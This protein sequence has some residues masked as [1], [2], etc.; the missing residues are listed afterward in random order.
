MEMNHGMLPFL[1]PLGKQK[2]NT[3]D[4]STSPQKTLQLQY[5]HINYNQ[6]KPHCTREI[7]NNLAGCPMNFKSVIEAVIDKY[8]SLVFYQSNEVRL[9]YSSCDQ[10]II[11]ILYSFFR[12][13]IFIFHVVLHWMI[14]CNLILFVL[15]VE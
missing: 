14:F 4:S 6:I 8:F 5:G 11:C 15:F 13:H 7:A 1:L 2:E 9:F 3:L 12:S 10:M